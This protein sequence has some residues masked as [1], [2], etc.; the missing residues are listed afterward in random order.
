MPFYAIV[1]PVYLNVCHITARYVALVSK[2]Y[3][4]VITFWCLSLIS[5]KCFPQN[6]EKMRILAIFYFYPSL[7]VIV[8]QCYGIHSNWSNFV[9][10]NILYQCVSKYEH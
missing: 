9:K 10:A 8:I 7:V 1:T 6:L 4:S 2:C 5:G 3:F